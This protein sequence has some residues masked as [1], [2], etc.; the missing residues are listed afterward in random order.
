[1]IDGFEDGIYH[2]SLS[3]DWGS[4]LH[5]MAYPVGKS[6]ILAMKVG[7][8]IWAEEKLFEVVL[9]AEC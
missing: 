1:M 3:M 9:F 6:F 4:S 7:I 5:N 8:Q 2:A